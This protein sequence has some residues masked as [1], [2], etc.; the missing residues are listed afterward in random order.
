MRYAKFGKTGLD[1][2]AIGMGTWVIGGDHW[3]KVD[4]SDSI[5]AIHAMI[6]NGVNLIDTAPGYN[7]GHSEDIVG[8]AIKGMRSKVLI[9]TKGGVMPPSF[10]RNSSREYLMEDLE[11]SL[12]HLQVDYADFYFIHWPD[13]ATPFEITMKALDD[14]KKQGKIRFVGVSNF[15]RQ[16]MEDASRYGV[17]D[18]VQPPYSMVDRSSEAL[19]RWAAGQGIAT[20]TYASMGAGVLS[21]AYRQ[22]PDFTPDDYRVSF[23]PYFKEPMFGKIMKLLNVMDAIAAKYDAT[24]GQVA[25]NWSTQK[26]FVSTAL[27]GVRSAKHAV[28][29]CNGMGWLL[30]AEEI[31][32]LDASIAEHL[33]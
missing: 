18:V 5:A 8:Q 25:I 27:V 28:E 30:T 21:G 6:D 2:S 11:R 1:V 17:I 33:G 23:Y 10:A 19:I 13:E 3:G 26:D 9:S 14:M 15:S 4:D 7:W 24:P 29:D 16:Q 31:A 32:L 12:K 20:M 22:I